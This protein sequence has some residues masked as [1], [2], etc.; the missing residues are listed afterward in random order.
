MTALTRRG[1]LAGLTAAGGALSLGISCGG[2]AQSARIRRADQTGELAP[3]MYI[4]VLPSGRIA[5]AVNKAEMGQGVTTAF[6]T[7]VAEE[8]DVALD[9]VDVHFADS[10]PEYRTSFGMQQTGGSTSTKEIYKPLRTAAASAR[11]MLVGAA[12]ASWGVAVEQCSTAE[13]KVRHDGSGRSAGYG[14]LTRLA[15]KR[16]VP[17]KPRLKPAAEFKLIGKPG[18]RVDARAKVDGSAVYGIDVVRPGMVRAAVV[19]GPSLGAEPRAVSEEAARA[20]PGVLDVLTF[21]WGVAVVADK[22]WQ[23]LAASKLLQ[24]EWKR[25]PLTGFDSDELRRAAREHRGRGVSARQDGD[26]DAALGAAATKLEATYEAP[27]LAHAPLEPQNCTVEVKGD[28]V[29]VWAPCQS[30]T[31]VQEMIAAAIG[32]AAA[33]VLVH[34]VLSGG[35]FG[36]R[37]MADYAAQAAMIAKRVGRPV[38]MIWTRESDMTQGF[39]RPQTTA[40]LRGGVD[41][42][43]RVIALDS[44]TIG[45]SIAVDQGTTLRAVM[46]P[47]MPAALKRVM[48]NSA[49]AMFGSGM[50]SEPF[51]TEGVRDT[52]YHFDNLRVEMTPV[53]TAIPVSF[54]RSVGHSFNAFAVESFLDELA[55]SAKRDPLELRRALLPTGTRA[56]RVLD[57]VAAMA[58]W[59]EPPAPGRGR[60]LAR[61]TSFES[62]VAEVAEVEIVDGRIRV[63]RVF[64]AIECGVAVNPD[65]IRAQ[66]EGAIVFG[67]SAALDQ[68]ITFVDGQVQQHNYDTFPPLRFH[69]CP[70]IEVQIV[71]SDEAPTGVGEPGLPPVAPAVA[72]AIFAAT[73]RRL[74]RMPLQL[75]WNEESKR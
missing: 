45:Q 15:A 21:P 73:G 5:V 27:Y 38:Q 56:R 31:V 9:A 11:E 61:H 70:V 41:A 57:A 28:R 71:A 62:E 50:L 75:A 33:D 20:A 47:G 68:Q 4:T 18:R 34:T 44:H 24:V 63:H 32:V 42:Q 55:H 43:G 48:A 66:V 12:A 10:R 74:R 65:I 17:G 59:G 53:S 52:A 72:N 58:R 29:E 30:P 40:R 36:R 7:L 3:N 69:E 1:F 37:G 19:H 8:L 13:G 67:L 26:C 23:A 49:V 14:E 2:G 39:Y 51:A 54:W 64:C 22:Y 46:P 60:G 6:A 16:D 35:G 25:G